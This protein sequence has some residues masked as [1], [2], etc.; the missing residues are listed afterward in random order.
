MNNNRFSLVKK[1]WLFFIVFTITLLILIILMTILFAII[2][3]IPTDWLPDLWVNLSAYGLMTLIFVPFVMGFRDRSQPYSA[4][5]SEIRLANWRPFLKLL[6]LGISCY[7]LFAISQIAGTL[8]YRISQGGTIDQSFLSSAFPISSEF[9]P[10]SLGF[11]GSLISVLEEVAFRGVILAL[12]LRHYDQRRAVL[13]SAIGFGVMHLF[14]LIGGQEPLWV[15]GNVVWALMLGLFYGY[16]TLK[17][18][19]LLPAM[20]VHYLGNLFIYPWTAYIQDNASTPVLMFYSI[21]F[22]MGIIPVVLMTLWARGFTTKWPV[23]A[24]PQP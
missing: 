20:L 21:I 10:N 8:V 2:L 16:V 19:S 18:N 4:Y 22:T 9:P 13:F 23:P 11:L 15:A 3:K 14:G 6:L 24:Q 1:P 5:L 7:L 12:F 17:S